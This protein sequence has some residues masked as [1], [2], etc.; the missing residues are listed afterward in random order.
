LFLW[1]ALVSLLSL[2][3]AQPGSPELHIDRSESTNGWM[4]LSSSLHSNTVLTLETAT[5]LDGWHEIATLHEALFGYPDAAA[6]DFDRRLYRLDLAS[7]TDADDWKNQILYPIESFRST[8][9]SSDIQWVKFAIL[10]S[11]PTRVY[12][13]DSKRYLFHYDFATRRLPPFL[14]MDYAGFEGV[15]LYRTNRQVVLGAVLY[16][17]SAGYY[18]PGTGFSEYG[19]QFVGLDPYTPD[20]IARW[21]DLVKATVYASNGAAA[22]YM[23][24]FEQAEMA[25]TNAEAFQGRGIPVA[26]AE[27]WVAVN[28]CYS[29]GWALGPLKYFPAA[30]ISAAFADGRLRP[31]DILLTDGVPADTPV[32]AGIISLVPATPNSHTAILSQ[33]FGTPF[34]YMSDPAEQSRLLTLI[35]H[36]IILRVTVV[37]ML[38][39]VKVIDVEG[40]LSPSL[41]AELLAQKAPEPIQF[42]RYSLA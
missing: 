20:E 18:P 2:A 6:P 14:G 3:R 23:P 8:N 36:K 34:V 40:Q 25:R 26:S 35:G 27:R 5:D 42:R 16:P 13:Q 9:S 11:E 31:E 17:P 19:V 37:Q 33:S 22:Y 30:E 4:L 41:E 1:A 7:R 24:S 10:L 29:A 15:S 21:F 28:T 12:Y 38:A 39:L 32:V